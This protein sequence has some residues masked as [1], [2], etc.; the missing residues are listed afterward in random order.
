MIFLTRLFFIV[1]FL[2]AISFI[3]AQMTLTDNVWASSFKEALE[4][5]IDSRKTEEEKQKQIE[6]QKKKE[7]E[8]RAEQAKISQ[9]TLIKQ[10]L[11]N[12]FEVWENLASELGTQLE[13]I[14]GDP[15]DDKSPSVEIQDFLADKKGECAFQ[16]IDNT[17]WD[18][19]TSRKAFFNFNQRYISIYTTWYNPNITLPEVKTNAIRFYN[20]RFISPE[21]I[22]DL[23]DNEKLIQ[24]KEDVKKYLLEN[25]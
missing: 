6:E 13:Y 4:K 15:A 1:L 10:A 8:I 24:F 22:S 9:C 3:D 20:G 25:L 18:R 11:F 17:M 16:F 19:H 5:R 7:A 12:Y 23:L 14:M 21:T 2:G